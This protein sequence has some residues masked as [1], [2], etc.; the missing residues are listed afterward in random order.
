MKMKW[1]V[2][3]FIISFSIK[4]A[5]PPRFQEARE[6]R[7]ILTSKNVQKKLGEAPLK[8]MRD[9]TMKGRIYQ[10]H[11]LNCRGHVKVIYNGK[12][13]KKRA[14]GWV[15]PACLRLE[16]LPVVACSEKP[17][18]HDVAKKEGLCK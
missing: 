9:H 13:C 3:F 17:L 6:I 11:S 12:G 2:L 1:F 7:R 8:A 18:C 15:G 14:R 5:L 10:V 4:A 16:V